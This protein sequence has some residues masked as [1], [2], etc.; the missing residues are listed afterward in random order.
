MHLE[1]KDLTTNRHAGKVFHGQLEPQISLNF[2][3]RKEGPREAKMDPKWSQE[4]AKINAKMGP[5][6]RIERPRETKMEPKWSQDE[7]RR[8]QEGPRGAERGQDG[9]KMGPRRN[10][11]GAKI[12]VQETLNKNSFLGPRAEEQKLPPV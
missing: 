9:D 12:D 7:A 6:G 3:V 10:Q 11:H 5:R 4:E 2:C 1:W 8:G